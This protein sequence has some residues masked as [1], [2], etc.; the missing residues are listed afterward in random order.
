[1]VGDAA[2]H[3]GK[4]SLPSDEPSSAR[5]RRDGPSGFSGAPNTFR[6]LPEPFPNAAESG[7]DIE[8]LAV[9]AGFGLSSTVVST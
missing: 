2:Q 5:A 9:K 8:F 4:P 6:A 3:V 7:R 1:M